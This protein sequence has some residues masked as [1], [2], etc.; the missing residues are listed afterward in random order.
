MYNAVYSKK[1]EVVFPFGEKMR[2]DDVR[3]APG[4]YV[5]AVMAGVN[6]FSV[7]ALSGEIKTFQKYPFG[8]G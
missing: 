3:F 2:M 1:I 8:H 4:L 7:P 5:N 6:I